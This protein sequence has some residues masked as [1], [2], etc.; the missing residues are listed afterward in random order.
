MK[1]VKSILIY[2]GLGLSSILAT[3]FAFVEL[4]SL[5]AGDFLLFNIPFVGAMSYLFRGLYYLFIIALCV[6]IV[7]FRTHHKKICIILFAT[8]VALFIGA[9]ISFIFYD[10]YISLVVVLITLIPLVITSIGFFKK[11]PKPIE[12]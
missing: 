2:V 8:S 6:F 11:E 7:L 1:L 5:F 4:R 3:V 10:Y 9:G 12:A